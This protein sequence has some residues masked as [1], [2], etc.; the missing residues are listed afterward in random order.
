MLTEQPGPRREG[1]EPYAMRE[2]VEA[3]ALTLHSDKTR[4]IE[5]GRYAVTNRKTG[6]AIRRPS[7]FWLYPHLR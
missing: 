6:S 2:R 4:L 1:E 3:F 5:F 7:R